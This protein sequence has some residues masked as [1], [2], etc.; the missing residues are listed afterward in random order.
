MPPHNPG[1]HPTTTENIQDQALGTEKFLQNKYLFRKYIAVDG[2]VK[3]QIIIEV[4]PVL[5]SPLM[6][7]LTGFGQVYALNML[8]HLSLSYGKIDKINLEGNSV[9]M[10]GTYDPAEPLA[11]L[12]DQL[13]K[14]REFAKAGGQMVAE[15]M[16]VSKGITL[17][18]H[19]EIFNNNIRDWQCQTSDQN[20]WEKFK[21]LFHRAHSEQRK[22]VTTAGKGGYTEAVKNIY[23][24]TTHPPSRGSASAFLGLLCLYFQ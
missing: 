3:K 11:R 10:M 17:L 12:I 13:E 5:L 6:D 22:A 15:T 1:N 4:E 2:D 21:I 16:M 18:A 9:N 8:Q 23:G 19:M 7:Q 24:V 14:G 20:T